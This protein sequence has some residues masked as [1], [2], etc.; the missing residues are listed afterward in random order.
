MKYRRLFVLFAILAVTFGT[1]RVGGQTERDSNTPI[2]VTSSPDSLIIIGTNEWVPIIYTFTNHTDGNI[3]IRDRLAYFLS[4]D[5]DVKTANGPLATSLRVPPHS[6][7]MF[8]DKAYFPSTLIQAFQKADAI[9]SGSFLFVQTFTAALDSTRTYSVA[10]PVRVDVVSYPP[11][12]AHVSK[13]AIPTE[14]SL[15]KGAGQGDALYLTLRLNERD[16]LLFVVDTGSAFTIL[17]QSVVTK[18]GNAIG[19]TL[20]E[21]GNDG[22]QKPLACF[23]APSLYL[24][25]TLLRTADWVTAWDLSLFRQVSGRPV[26][27][28]LGM[29][30]LIHYCIQLDCDAGKL[31]FLDPDHPGDEASGKVFPLTTLGDGRCAVSENLMDVEGVRTLI[32][33]GFVGT[34]S[35][36]SNLFAQAINDARIHSDFARYASFSGIGES[37]EG[38]FAR[39][40]LGGQ[41]YRNLILHEAKTT[42]L[43]LD[44]LARHRVTLNFPKLEMYLKR[45]TTELADD[46]S[47]MSGLS[48]I[49]NGEATVVNSVDRDGPAERAGVKAGDVVLKVNSRPA[50]ELELWEIRKMLAAGDGKE[51]RFTVQR[52][53]KTKRFTIV[54]KRKL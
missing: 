38:R 54:L 49:R 53:S 33:T 24:G 41:T 46:E 18:L 36:Q 27:G 6:I 37:R 9:K 51:V 32:D 23:K 14:V 48:I 15:N 4:F 26:M 39:C 30:C 5:R 1:L 42:F 22:K 12:V 19:A 2:S 28:I 47:G 17:D 10:V 7:A 43:G 20:L 31:R 21:D 34:G 44:F 11:T 40:I 45:R 52:A 29:D 13:S 35:L 50:K 3:R 25:K 8:P 16:E